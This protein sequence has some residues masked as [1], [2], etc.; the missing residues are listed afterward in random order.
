MQLGQELER[1]RVVL[2]VPVDVD[3]HLRRAQVQQLVH[4]PVDVVRRIRI[5]PHFLVHDAQERDRRIADMPLD[6]DAVALCR[7]VKLPQARLAVRGTREDEREREQG[8]LVVAQVKCR[9]GRDLREVV[10]NSLA[11]AV[12]H[13][14]EIGL[15][16]LH[17]LKVDRLVLV[18][19]ADAHDAARRELLMQIVRGEIVGGGH[20]RV[21]REH[22]ILKAD[23]DDTQGRIRQYGLA[24]FML[25]DAFSVLFAI[26]FF[27]RLAFLRKTRGKL[28]VDRRRRIRAQNGGVEPAE[29]FHRLLRFL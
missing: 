7:I 20:G 2:L 12:A 13:D 4:E 9:D 24:E 23:A 28:R 26:E 29:F 22:G 19:D 25:Q 3:H 6:A 15:R 5:E 14:D 17:L 10:V 18:V 8:T 1:D 11:E 27:R 16:R 21:E